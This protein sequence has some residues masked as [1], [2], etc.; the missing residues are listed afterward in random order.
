MAI[1]VTTSPS[2]LLHFHTNSWSWKGYQGLKVL[3]TSNPKLKS[4]NFFS[5]DVIFFFFCHE[6]FTIVSYLSTIG[7][8]RSLN[9]LAQC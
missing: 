4:S 1:L 7:H 6:L 8:Y 3:A 5:T 2:Q 9:V